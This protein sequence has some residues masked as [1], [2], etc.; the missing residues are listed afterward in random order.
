MIEWSKYVSTNVYKKFSNKNSATDSIYNAVL[1]FGKTIQFVFR[2][3]NGFICFAKISIK[4]ITKMIKE[5]VD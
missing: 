5:F 1:N 3:H 4:V 2:K